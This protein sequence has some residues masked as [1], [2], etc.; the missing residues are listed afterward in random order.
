MGLERSPYFGINVY[1]GATYDDRAATAERFRDAVREPSP[2]A[3]ARLT[4]ENDDE[5]GLW[6]VA[7]LVGAVS[8]PVDVPVVL[9]YHHHT[10]SDRGISYRVSWR[11]RIRTAGHW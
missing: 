7:D 3:R 1:I 9:D 8:D 5:A 4:V 11:I 10:F 2:G 6:G